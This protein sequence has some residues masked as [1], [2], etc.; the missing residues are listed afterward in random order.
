MQRDVGRAFRQPDRQ[1]DPTCRHCFRLGVPSPQT[2]SVLVRDV[3]AN[4]TSNGNGTTAS[5]VIGMASICIG[6]HR[7]DI[8]HIM[9]VAFLEYMDAAERAGLLLQQALAPVQS[10]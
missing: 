7:R 9:P 10:A 1:P 3:A 2:R 4:G 8:E 5:A 6:G